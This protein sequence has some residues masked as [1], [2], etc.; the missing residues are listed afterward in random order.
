[1]FV[2]YVNFS[3]RFSAEAALERSKRNEAWAKKELALFRSK[4]CK[5]EAEAQRMF[6]NVI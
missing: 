3:F 6:G 4:M 1:M 5:D 2:F